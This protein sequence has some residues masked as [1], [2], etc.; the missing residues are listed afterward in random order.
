MDALA[1]AVA[2]YRQNNNQ[3]VKYTT[4]RKGNRELVLDHFSGTNTITVTDADIEQAKTIANCLAQQVT[5]SAL[6]GKKISGFYLDVVSLLAKSSMSQNKVGILVWAPK[7]HDDDIKRQ[8]TADTV[9]RYSFGSKYI[10]S[11]KDKIAITV[12][13]LFKRF[14]RDYNCYS[15]LCNDE[16]GNLIGFLSKFDL[17]EGNNVKLTGRIK[18]H[19]TTS[20]FNNGK[21]TYLNYVKV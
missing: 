13:V 10:G 14:V 12:N 5:L 7:L 9:T 21:V 18:N 1:C 4:E 17:T 8:D 19:G 6:T 15:Y 2:V 16:N 3:V 11:K 20:K